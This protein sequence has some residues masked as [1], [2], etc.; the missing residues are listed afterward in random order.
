MRTAKSSNVASVPSPNHSGVVAA[1]YLSSEDLACDLGVTLRT[2]IRWRDKR[3]GPPTTPIGRRVFYRRDSVR[4]W[5][6]ENEGRVKVGPTR[7]NP[8]PEYRPRNSRRMA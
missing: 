1:E 6:L 8:K 2:L 5:L 4:A 7:L 3:T